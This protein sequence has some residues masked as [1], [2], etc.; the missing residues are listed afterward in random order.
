MT[1]TQAIVAY[2]ILFVGLLLGLVLAIGWQKCLRPKGFNLISFNARG[3]G[4]FAN[5]MRQLADGEFWLKVFLT[6]F[7]TLCGGVSI[8]IFMTPYGGGWLVIGL[9]ALL[10]ILAVILPYLLA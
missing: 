1:L 10:L 3:R 4:R 6:T 9:L 2:A 7:I 8:A 5:Q